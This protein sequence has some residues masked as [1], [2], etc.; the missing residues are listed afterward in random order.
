MIA[1][2][3]SSASESIDLPDDILILLAKD[4]IRERD[5]LSLSLSLATMRDLP[6]SMDL[7]GW[8]HLLVIF[9]MQHL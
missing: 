3:E 8:L 7:T 1:D 2:E 6:L 5:G 4:Y 9:I